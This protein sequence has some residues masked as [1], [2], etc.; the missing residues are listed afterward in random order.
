MGRSM[1]ETYDVTPRGSRTRVVHDVRVNEPGV[2]VLL[3]ILVWLIMHTGRPAGKTVMQRFA[4][5]AES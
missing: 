5:I 3:R 2:N 4:E 1:I